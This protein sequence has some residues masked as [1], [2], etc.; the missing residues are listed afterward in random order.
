MRWLRNPFRHDPLP[1]PDGLWRSCTG[2]LPFLD[3]L[4]PAENAR[5]KRL[6]ETFLD[7]K[8]FVGAAGFA[9]S[10]D[11]AVLIA[12]QAALPILNL[13]LDLYADLGRI[14]VYP[15]AFLV[16][17]S[18]TDEAGVV[19]ESRPALAGE[20]IDAGGAVILS[21]EDLER[22]ERGGGNVVIHE[23]A[24][25]IDMADGSANG[26]PPF[27]AGYHRAA[28]RD[29][30]KSVFSAAFDD[31]RERLQEVPDRAAATAGLPLDPYAATHPAEFFAVATET[32]FV[33][34]EPLAAG[35]PEVF[36]LLTMY[37]RQNPLAQ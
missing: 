8:A 34:P 26:C 15:S 23:F 7:E 22:P 24:H 10:D 25:K 11:I 6:C 29:E 3:R 1:I 2:R 13:T 35:Y 27:L 31:F 12:A 18:E 5:L 4:A 21:W 9:V 36:R 33:D 16:P 17:R 20:A 30:W 28:E 19:H 37:Y 32:F 14:I